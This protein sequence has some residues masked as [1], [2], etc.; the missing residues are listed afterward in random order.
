MKIAF[1]LAGFHRYDRGAETA[2]IALAR[3]LAATG[4]EVTLIGSG[5]KRPGEPYRFIH[6]GSVRREKFER[7][8]RFPALRSETGWEEATFAAGL[9]RAFRAADY[10]LTISCGYPW[11]NWALRRSGRRGPRHVFVTQNGDYPAQSDASEFRFFGCD[12]LVCTNPDYFE[13]NKDRWN[14]ALIPNGIDPTC[15]SIGD[16]ERAA[17]GLAADAPIVLMVSACIETKRVEDGIRAVAGV[18]GVHLVVAGDGPLRDKL[19]ALADAMLPGRFTRLTAPAA[20]MPAL[21]RSANAFLHMSKEESFG[22]VYIEAMACGLPVVGHDTPRLR[23]IVG[24][25]EYLADTTDIAATSARIAQALGEDGAGAEQRAAKAEAFAWPRVA[26][27]Y[28]T[29]FEQVV[30]QSSVRK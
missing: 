25:D 20:R 21:Y 22:N 14:C 6:A 10:D 16:A 5:E 23:W 28:R 11:T 18:P 13:R 9:L 19:Q 24:D 29:F 30:R 2:L 26:A 3:E 27:Q 1:A 8:P 17:F 15:F 12:G 7:F 4:D